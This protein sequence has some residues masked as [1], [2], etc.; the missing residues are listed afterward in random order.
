MRRLL[1]HWGSTFSRHFCPSPSTPA[2]PAAG[3]KSATGGSVLPPCCWPWHGN[4]CCCVPGLSESHAALLPDTHAAV[5]CPVLLLLHSER[6][7]CC[8]GT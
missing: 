7:V 8:E 5:G 3:P 2:T 1:F 6:C 4:G